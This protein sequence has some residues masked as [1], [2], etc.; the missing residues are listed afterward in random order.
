[1]KAD[2]A[3]GRSNGASGD[4]SQWSVVERLAHRDGEV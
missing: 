2:Y 3:D 4:D 1:M